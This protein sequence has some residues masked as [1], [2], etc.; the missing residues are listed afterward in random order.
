MIKATE[1]AARMAQRNAGLRQGLAPV[2]KEA[3]AQAT[4]LWHSAQDMK[5]GAQFR[6]EERAVHDAHIFDLFASPPTLAAELVADCRL[7]PGWKV[8]EPS[9]GTGRIALAIRNSGFEPQ[10][11][12]FQQAAVQLLRKQG[13]EVWAGD[14]LEF[15]QTFDA[16]VM[17]PPFSSGQD[18]AHVR[19][20]YDLLNPGG[21]LVSVMGEGAFYRSDKAATEFRAWLARV[22]GISLRLPDGSFK[23]S[24]TGVATRKVIISKD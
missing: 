13:F 5:R 6:Q 1:L 24:G 4:R 8:C 3:S 12:E 16:F 18:I 7:Q 23:A 20:A 17:N 14:F 11:V 21:R 9:A 15:T 10:C 22:G 19:H 2:A